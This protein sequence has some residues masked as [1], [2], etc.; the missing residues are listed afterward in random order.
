[1]NPLLWLAVSSSIVSDKWGYAEADRVATAL[2]YYCNFLIA[3]LVCGVIS[4]VYSVIHL[5]VKP[6]RQL[7]ARLGLILHAVGMIYIGIVSFAALT[8]TRETPR[9]S[10]FEINE[11]RSVGAMISGNALFFGVYQTIG[12]F[13]K[14]FKP[15]GAKS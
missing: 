2:L 11:W 3:M 8:L 15:A 9:V 10:A 6:P 7:P 4:V 5:I 12:V 13:I 1:M 14:A